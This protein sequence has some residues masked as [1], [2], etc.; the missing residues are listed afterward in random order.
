MAKKNKKKPVRPWC[1]Y[2]E[3]D[4][5]D[6]KVLISHQRAKHFKCTRCSKK[7]NTAG[8]MRVHVVQV[9]KETINAV[10]NAMPGRETVDLE[11]YGMEGIPEEDMIAYMAKQ[12]ALDNPVSKRAKVA[13]SSLE[14]SEEDLQSQLAAHKA[15]MQQTASPAA[16]AP[17]MP[18][19]PMPPMIPG[20]PPPGVP[21]AGPPGFPSQPPPGMPGPPGI[22]GTDMRPPPPGQGPF[23]GQYYP[24]MPPAAAS[25]MPAA[26]SQ[27]YQPRPPQP[28]GVPPHP[29]MSHPG[30]PPQFPPYGNQMPPGAWPPHAP[31]GP[32]GPHAPPGAPPHMPPHHPGFAPPPRF[33]GGPP[34]PGFAPPGMPSHIPYGAPPRPGMPLHFPPGPPG[35]PM[36][37]APP[38]PMPAS[39]P[40]SGPPPGIPHSQIH[41]LKHTSHITSSPDPTTLAAAATT[42]TTSASSTTT[43]AAPT[44]ASAPTVPSGATTSAPVQPVADASKP[45]AN[46]KKDGVLVYSNNDV[47]VEEVR[48]GLERYRFRPQVESAA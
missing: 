26:Y 12:D 34:P 31:Q 33:M 23:P 18:G 43:I 41:G 37:S 32:P 1:W 9:H 25:I 30:A 38:R 8:G 42:T 13:T 5:E 40:P 6:E 22:P 39:F 16:G 21:V 45:V 3:R 44:T 2:C 10:P 20:V 19:A 27:F 35:G 17:T 4:F 15:M 46:A 29:G 48:A 24:G 14:F 36:G 28:L 47:S 7:L 11:I